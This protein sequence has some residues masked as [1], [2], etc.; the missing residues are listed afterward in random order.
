MYAVYLPHQHCRIPFYIQSFRMQMQPRGF[1]SS[2]TIFVPRI[3]IP[4]M[5]VR[6]IGSSRY[7]C[8]ALMLVKTILWIT[9]LAASIHLSDSS[10]GVLSSGCKVPQAPDCLFSLWLASAWRTKNAALGSG[11]PFTK[12]L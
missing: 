9:M 5:L 1:H 12:K 11:G 4:F 2:G 10:T 6:I 7:Y 3:P 8:V